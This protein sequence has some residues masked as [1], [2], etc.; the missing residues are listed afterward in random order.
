MV[1]IYCGSL[2]SVVN[3][4]PQVRNNQV[5]RRRKCSSCLAVFSTIEKAQLETNWLVMN[6]KGVSTPF[7]SDKLML[8]IFDSCS[9]RENSIS[10][11]RSISDTV[12]HKLQTKYKS[13]HIKA[14]TIAQYTIVALNR[15]DKAASTYYSVRHPV[16]N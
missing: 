16:N 11:A 5:W 9:H 7:S 3:S 15:F 2:T 6:K 10:D 4:R 13:G 14:Q 8:S 1:C 12:I